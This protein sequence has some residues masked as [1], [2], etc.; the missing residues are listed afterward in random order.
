MSAASE[1][2]ASASAE[3]STNA[4]A[5]LLGLVKEAFGERIL[6]ARPPG[7]GTLDPAVTIAREDLREVLQWLRDDERM[8]FDLLHCLTAVDY[9][10]E[11]RVTLVYNLDSVALRHTLAVFVHLPREDASC[12][13]VESIWK[14]ADWHER[15]AWDLMG[16]RFE[17]H[18]NLVRI[19][20]AEDWE[21]HPLR[22]DYVMPRYYHGIPN[23][24]DMFYDVQNP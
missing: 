19:L 2:G 18:P 13:S 24:F 14:T 22:K 6:E 12:D 7:S 9:P 23:D 16:V 17:G 4:G 21:G 20:C 8:R 15:E 1:E 3:A 11:Q 10:Q 5:R